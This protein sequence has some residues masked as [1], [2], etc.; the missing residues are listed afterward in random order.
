[1]YLTLAIRIF[2]NVSGRELEHGLNGQ[3]GIFL[4]Y[5]LEE[6]TKYEFFLVFMNQ[7]CL[8]EFQ[9]EKCWKVLTKRI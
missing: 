4:T 8:V 9:P 2:Y 3:P 7:D 1:M 6:A 5:S